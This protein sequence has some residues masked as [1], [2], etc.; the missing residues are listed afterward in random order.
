VTDDCAIA[1]EDAAKAATAIT[2][3]LILLFFI[4]ISV[5]LSWLDCL[6]AAA[7]EDKGPPATQGNEKKRLSQKG[8]KGRNVLSGRR[9][10][11]YSVPGRQQRM[12]DRFPAAADV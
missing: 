3:A 10:M 9:L 5:T 12:G 1:A 6:F 2:L 7:P 8:N 11:D 4:C